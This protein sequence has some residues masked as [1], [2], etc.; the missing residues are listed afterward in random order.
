[1]PGGTITV[2]AGPGTSYDR[3]GELR[4]GETRRIT[5]RNAGGDWWQFSFDGQNG[6]VYGD[7]ITISGDRAA[8]P[9]VTPPPT[10]A[11]RCFV[12]RLRD[13]DYH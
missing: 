1:V 11:V 4:N 2:R 10:P 12:P 3:I 9:V 6:W 13:S 5:G 8:A 7:F